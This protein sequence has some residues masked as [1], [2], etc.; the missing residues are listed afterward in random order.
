[1]S[2]SRPALVSSALILSLAVLPACT[3]KTGTADEENLGTSEELLTADDSEAAAPDDSSEAEEEA[4]SGGADLSEAAAGIDPSVSESDQIA[5]VKLN[6]GRFFQPAGCI[7]STVAG[8]VVT[9]VFTG[10]T[11]PGGR[12]Y[13]GT[14]VATWSRADGVISVQRVARG[15]RIDGATDDRRVN[16]SYSREDGVFK[17]VRTVDMSGT[18]GKGKA[19][20]RQAS[21]TMTWDP[22]TKCVTRDGSSVTRIGGREHSTSVVGY[23]RCGVGYFGCPDAG[24]ITL[25]R[26]AGKGSDKDI[27]I[28]IEFVGG[29]R[30]SVEVPGGKKIERT[31]ACRDVNVK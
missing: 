17:R 26:K 10:C 20:S 21:W 12:T 24:K 13:D 1:M 27:T 11:G 23:K 6:A 22:S 15:F 5:K 4:T 2:L 29:Q 28:V 9:H 14:V 25:N 30:M 7:A 16:V 3:A 19:L 18:T 31:M 8:N